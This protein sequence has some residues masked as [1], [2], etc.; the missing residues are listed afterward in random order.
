[1]PT[2]YILNEDQEKWLTALESGEYKQCSLKLFDGE[3]FCCLG[4]GCAVLGM[5]EDEL[6]GHKS[7]LGSRETAGVMSTLKLRS[8]T[9]IA[10]HATMPSLTQLN[11]RK[12]L[13][14]KQIAGVIR[15]DP[16]VYFHE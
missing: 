2:E 9:G 13:T 7:L 12:G 10:I 15:D 6:E 3:K 14:L 4:V 1:M 16:S 11:D 5:K 8:P